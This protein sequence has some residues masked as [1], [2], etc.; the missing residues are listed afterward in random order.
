MTIDIEHFKAKLEQEKRELEQAIAGL[1]SAG[2]NESEVEF[3]DEVADRL[4]D[5]EE[6]EEEELSLGQELKEVKAALEKIAKGT[7]GLCEVSGEPI[8]ADRLE[9]NPAARICK[10]HLNVG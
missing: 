8:E 10:Q 4:E 7:Y 9:A 1:T 3:N 6:R 2:K 5:Q